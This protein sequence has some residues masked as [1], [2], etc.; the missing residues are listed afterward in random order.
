M[1]KPLEL[2]LDTLTTP[3]VPQAAQVTERPSREAKPT[4]TRDTKEPMQ[5]RWPGNEVK[6]ARLAA[7]QLDFPTVSEFMLACFHAYMEQEAQLD[8]MNGTRGKA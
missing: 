3:A 1:P 4:S 2:T 7:L 8:R 6:A 5:V